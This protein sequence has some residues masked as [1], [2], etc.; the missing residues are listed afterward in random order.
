MTERKYW[1]QHAENARMD[2]IAL[3]LDMGYLQVQLYEALSR[4]NLNEAARLNFV[5]DKKRRRIIYL[6]QVAKAGISE[7]EK[8]AEL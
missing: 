4:E 1:P 7:Y 6:A 5:I 3:A 8:E 2:I